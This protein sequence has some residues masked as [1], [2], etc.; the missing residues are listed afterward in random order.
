MHRPNGVPSKSRVPSFRGSSAAPGSP[1]SGERRRPLGPSMETTL[2]WRHAPDRPA[3][4]HTAAKRWS[5][6]RQNAVRPAVGPSCI[7]LPSASIRHGR[8]PVT[9][10]TR[11]G[12]GRGTARPATAPAT[13]SAGAGR[14]ARRN[15]DSGLAAPS[16]SGPGARPTLRVNGPVASTGG[17][18]T[19]TCSLPSA[20]VGRRGNDPRRS[21]SRHRTRTIHSS[22]GPGRSSASSGSDGTITS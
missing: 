4:C 18:P 15:G 8:V 21:S 19:P 13:P 20:G 5:L 3:A 17:R 22:S 10:R 12:V 6:C 16:I 1:S 14:C 9:I 7:V 2:A 11:S